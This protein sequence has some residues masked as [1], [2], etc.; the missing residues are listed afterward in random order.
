[1]CHFGSIGQYAGDSKICN[2]GCDE[3]GIS[4]LDTHYRG[5]TCNFHDA[6]AREK[7]VGAFEIAVQY[8]VGVNEVSE[9]KL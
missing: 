1:M 6:A 4:E 5:A 2:D 7:H 8:V 9:M 3:W